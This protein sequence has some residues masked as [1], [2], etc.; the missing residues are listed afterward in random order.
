[1]VNAKTGPV[2][3]ILG[4]ILVI[5]FGILTT[6]AYVDRAE[7]GIEFAYIRLAFALGV[8]VAI[9]I[10]GILALRGVKFGNVIPLIVAVIAIVGLFVPI[11]EI[12]VYV[13]IP[14][15]MII[16]TPVTLFSTL[17]YID[18]ILMCFGG[19]LGLLVN[20]IERNESK[21]TQ[22]SARRNEV[23][24]KAEKLL[25][26]YLRENKG[27][28]F[29]AKSLHKKCI[30]DNNLDVSIVETEKI[31]HDFYLLGRCRLDVKENVNYYFTS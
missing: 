6:V 30:E 27:K 29:I 8:G 11:G 12:G 18:I 1:M 28:A 9:I 13:T 16:D 3:C 23:L 22:I 20:L 21:K 24:I 26:N 4:S 7:R 25:L 17:F 15:P 2:I 19:L 14:S 31:L 5:G 10:G